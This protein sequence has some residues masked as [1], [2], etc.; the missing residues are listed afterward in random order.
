VKSYH[1]GKKR[2][3]SSKG[4]RRHRGDRERNKEVREENRKE[5]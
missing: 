4:M 3:I 2:K 1:N 5:D